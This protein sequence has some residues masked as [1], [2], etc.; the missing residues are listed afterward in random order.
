[1][2]VRTKIQMYFV[3]AIHPETGEIIEVQLPRWERFAV[4]KINKTTTDILLPDGY[5]ATIDSKNL[6]E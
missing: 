1:M 2:T 4:H 5:I 6:E 3:E